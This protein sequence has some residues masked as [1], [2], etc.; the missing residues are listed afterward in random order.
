ML[1]EMVRFMG[2][3][4]FHKIEMFRGID[5][6]T[7]QPVITFHCSKILKPDYPSLIPEVEEKTYT[8]NLELAEDMHVL[9]GDEAI[10]AHF[11]N[12]EQKMIN[13]EDVE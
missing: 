7:F 1:K 8:F 9:V 4:K 10:D 11:S 12:L 2:A 3:G 5:A 6:Q 13:F